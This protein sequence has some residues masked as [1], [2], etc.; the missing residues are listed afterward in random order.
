MS[1]AFS[2]YETPSG[3]IDGSNAAFS[4]SEVP[5]PSESLKLFRNGLM[6]TAGGIDYTLSSAAVTF[7]AGAQPQSGDSLAAWYRY[8]TTV[9]P[10][11]PDYVLPKVGGGKRRKEELYA[12]TYRGERRL[13]TS[14]D[15][16]YNWFLEV[17]REEVEKAEEKA[18]RDAQRIILKAKAPQ[19][20]QWPTV[21][22]RSLD[23]EVREGI[24]EVEKYVRQKYHEALQSALAAD[25]EE[26]DDVKFIA[27]L[28]LE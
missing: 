16:L 3:T 13:F 7:A 21:P 5:T 28:D 25:A 14:L 11:A 12:L 19:R 1:Q 9:T 20:T 26:V 2:A 15:A 24:S 23:P 10:P 17:T 6:M 4:L 22:I 27:E 18:E 8:D